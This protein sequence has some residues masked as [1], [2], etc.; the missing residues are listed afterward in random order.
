MAKPN[1]T[2]NPN[3]KPK[4]NQVGEQLEARRQE[5]RVGAL[6]QDE[7]GEH[8]VD[9]AHLAGGAALDAHLGEV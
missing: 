5:H 1:P 3:P 7:Q 9:D 4:P 8:H 2:P 6:G